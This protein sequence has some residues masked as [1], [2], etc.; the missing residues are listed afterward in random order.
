[1]KPPATGHHQALA[2]AGLSAGAA[3]ALAPYL[4]LLARWSRRVNLTAAATSEER[5]AL[6]V[7]PVAPLAAALEPGR[8]LDIGSGNGSPGLVL[9]LLRPDLQTTLLEPRT[10]RW[11]FLREAARACG[12]GDIEVRPWRHE[13]YPGPACANVTIRALALPLPALLSFLAPEGQLFVWGEA[14]VG[15]AGRELDHSELMVAG[16]RVHRYR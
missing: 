2:A 11:A 8:L 15:P 3:A 6:L 9:A 14:P 10:R 16:R 13:A 7:A 1:V 4:D 5:V 12:R